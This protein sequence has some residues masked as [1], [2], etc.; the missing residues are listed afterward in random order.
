MRPFFATG[1]IQKDNLRCQIVVRQGSKTISSKG[2]QTGAQPTRS[3]Q[4]K[5]K[6]RST[7]M[8]PTSWTPLSG[9]SCTLPYLWG[10]PAALARLARTRR[11]RLHWHHA[12]TPLEV[13]S[14]NSAVTAPCSQKMGP[15][16]G[17]ISGTFFRTNYLEKTS[18]ARKKRQRD[19]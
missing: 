16:S 1:R 10:L 14:T 4:T 17:P 9:V 6:S 11:R 15:Y 2:R 19:F 3:R 18:T 12:I 5:T 13:P 7:G 8:A